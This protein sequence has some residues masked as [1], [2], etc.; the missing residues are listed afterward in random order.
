MS[1]YFSWAECRCWLAYRLPSC[2]W[3]SHELVPSMQLPVG[4]KLSIESVLYFKRKRWQHTRLLLRRTGGLM[5]S[6]TSACDR[7][8]PWMRREERTGGISTAA[9]LGAKRIGQALAASGSLGEWQR[10]GHYRHW[11]TGSDL[12]N[13]SSWEKLRGLFSSPHWGY[14][15]QPKPRAQSE[16]NFEQWS[17]SVEI[18]RHVVKRTCNRQNIQWNKLWC[19]RGRR[20]S[21]GK[22]QHCNACS[23][24]RQRQRLCLAC[25]NYWHGK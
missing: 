18:C 16:R 25:H 12:G 5:S 7:A 1:T 4:G 24:W 15:L 17:N 8:D 20:V 14:A 21:S 13:R 23:L 6:V 3:R 2:V 9:S 11:N 19:C 22:W 10:Q